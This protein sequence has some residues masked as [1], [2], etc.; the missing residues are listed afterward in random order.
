MTD[1]IHVAKNEK[2]YKRIEREIKNDPRKIGD[3]F[4]DR[5]GATPISPAYITPEKK[6]AEHILE[7]DK[8]VAVELYNDSSIQCLLKSIPIKDLIGPMNIRF[9]KVNASEELAKKYG[10]TKL[11]ALLFFK[12]GRLLGSIQGY[13]EEENKKDLKEKIENLKIGQ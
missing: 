12:E 9:Q 13:W 1:S 4:V 5:Y 2:E 8:L 3:L 7:Y 10:L 6:F 11:P